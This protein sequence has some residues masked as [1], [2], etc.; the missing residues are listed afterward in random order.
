[1]ADF[2]TR[3]RQAGFDMTRYWEGVERVLSAQAAQAPVP[4]LV[5]LLRRL[6]LRLGKDGIAGVVALLR[7]PSG[8]WRFTLNQAVE[9]QV[10]PAELGAQLERWVDA[11][12]RVRE[13]R[14]RNAIVPGTKA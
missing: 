11:I 4:R 13:A 10:T 6:Q 3:K 9:Q 2:L 8:T 7:Q 1:L 12:A 5:L 14:L